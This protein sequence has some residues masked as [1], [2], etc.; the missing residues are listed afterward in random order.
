MEAMEGILDI[1]REVG[2]VGNIIGVRVGGPDIVICDICGA[3][4]VTPC[5]IEV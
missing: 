5:P 3:I 1:G 2:W 4:E